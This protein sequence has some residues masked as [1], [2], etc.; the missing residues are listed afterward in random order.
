MI[1]WETVLFHNNYDN[2]EW[3]YSLAWLPF[4]T[5]RMKYVL[6]IETTKSETLTLCFV[7]R[8][9]T[10]SNLLWDS[11]CLVSRK[12]QEIVWYTMIKFVTFRC[13]TKMLQLMLLLTKATHRE[14]SLHF[15]IKYSTFFSKKLEIN[16]DSSKVIRI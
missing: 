5:S 9:K 12:I 11:L 7:T 15:W 1:K 6:Y 8:L 14:L 10:P 16:G 13:R 2:L 4:R 3:S